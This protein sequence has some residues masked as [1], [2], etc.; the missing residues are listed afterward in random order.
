MYVWAV[1]VGSLPAENWLLVLQGLHPQI[2]LT[3][4]HKREF[5]H[6]EKGWRALKSRLKRLL[7]CRS[8]WQVICCLHQPEEQPVVKAGGLSSRPLALPTLL[9]HVHSSQKARE[10]ECRPTLGSL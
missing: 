1:W 7:P 10:L 2:L 4:A 3:H 9:I 5:R 8:R 6:L